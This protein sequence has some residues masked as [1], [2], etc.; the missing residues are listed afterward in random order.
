MSALHAEPPTNAS[1]AKSRRRKVDAECDHAHCRARA[2]RR[3]APRK[4]KEP[5]ELASFVEHVIRLVR[6]D[7]GDVA[8]PSDVLPT[9]VHLAKVVDD[10]LHQAVRALRDRPDP[11]TWEQIGAQLGVG[12][13][14]AH[15][16]FGGGT[17]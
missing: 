2:R 17:R 1:G 16:R 13:T 8:E 6:R 12:K 4:Q 15:K 7:A 14:A 3:S 11:Y 10:E 9:L 5:Q